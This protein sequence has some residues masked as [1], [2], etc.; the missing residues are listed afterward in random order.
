MPAQALHKVAPVAISLR[1]LHNATLSYL[2]FFVLGL[3]MAAL[4]Q[5]I[6]LS[7][8]ASMIYE[9][10]NMQ[11]LQDASIFSVMV[12]KLLPYWLC[13]T[14]SF[15][16]ALI[17]SSQVFHIPFNGDFVSLLVL[18]SIFSFTIT[19]FGSLMAAYCRSEVTFTQ[20]SLAY[21]VP[22]FVFSGYTWPQYTM[23]TISTMISYTFPITYVADTV[24][25]L[26]IAGHAPALQKNM[27]ILLIVGVILL[28]LSTLTYRNR[29]KQLAD[30]SQNKQISQ[31]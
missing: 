26:M 29:R 19:V 11:E 9:Y 14:L 18:G 10:K 30:M 25:A 20:F 21:A 8:G 1:V 15:V 3:A 24:R 2:D 13:S 27:L 4:Q 28:A 16:M 5:G 7:I 6:L 31:C 12:G 17:I 23:D 22:G